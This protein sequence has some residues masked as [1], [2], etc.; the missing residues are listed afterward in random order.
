MRFCP[1]SYDDLDV[2]TQPDKEHCKPVHREPFQAPPEQIGHLRL[3]DAEDLSGL[4]LVQ[5]TMFDDAAD[6][7]G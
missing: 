7:P 6:L 5:V 4:C 1:D 3:V 2:A